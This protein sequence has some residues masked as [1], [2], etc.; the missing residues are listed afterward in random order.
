MKNHIP[1]IK[2]IRAIF[3]VLS[4]N[5]IYLQTAAANP[6]T[7]QFTKAWESSDI[8]IYGTAAVIDVTF[9]NFG[10]D[11]A[12]QTYYWQDITAVHFK[13][14][15]GSYDYT[16]SLTDNTLQKSIVQN[17]P[18]LTT[19]NSGNAGLFTFDAGRNNVVY[20]YTGEDDGIPEAEYGAQIGTGTY[21]NLYERVTYYGGGVYKGGSTWTVGAINVSAPSVP[22]NVVLLLHGMNSNPVTWNPVVQKYFPE[23]CSVITNGLIEADA[24]PNT[25]N[26]YCYSVKFGAFDADSP[27]SLENAWAY[28]ETNGYD[29]AGDYSTFD[30]LGIEVDKAI[31]G[32]RKE[33][34]NAKILLIGHSRGGLAARAFLQNPF[35]N[36]TSI[37]GLL[38]TGTPHNGTRLGRVHQYIKTRLLKKGG[39]RKTSSILNPDD[40]WIDDDWDAIDFLS[41]KTGFLGYKIDV[42]R[43]VVGYLADNSLMIKNLND[44]KANLPTIKY[45]QLFYAKMP[46]GDLDAHYAI[47]DDIGDL[48]DQVSTNAEVYIKG[49]LADGTPKPSDHL[50]L[51][52]DGIVP[53]A[54]QSG[55]ENATITATTKLAEVRHVDEP[56]RFADISAMTCKLSFSWLKSCPATTQVAT[57]KQAQAPFKPVKIV[58]HDYDA[59]VALKTEQLWQDW[60]AVITDDAKANQREQFAV[61]LGIKLRD[62]DNTGLYA[63]IEQ[64]VLN[65]NS[66]KLERARLAKLLAEVATPAALEILTNA[67]LNPDCSAIQT[68]LSNAILTVADS[69]PE[70]PRRADLSTVLET[71][72]TIPKQNQH[73]LN[74][75]ALALAKLGTPRGVELLLMAVDKTGTFMPSTKK[76]SLSYTEQQAKAAFMAMDEIINPDSEKMLSSAFMNHR[77][78]E[79]VFIAAGN[80]LV[81]LGSED[82]AQRVLQRLNELPDNTLSVGQH[83]LSSLSGKIDKT[84]L[85][86]M[87]KAVG[88]PRQGI[89]RQQMEEMVK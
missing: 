19:D 75:L 77:A 7:Y 71:A 46:L 68:A 21:T 50:S 35:D 39:T 88:M 44:G 40:D 47:F 29:S 86:R 27:D 33:L 18:F 53:K 83:W 22:Q 13:T 26:T 89:L 61:A 59:L 62:S 67:L 63:D 64:R 76:K 30:Q 43:P 20:G 5:I 56:G 2:I 45:G 85:R 1:N 58:S 15:S 55:L 41:G 48:L 23:G 6:Y 17:S 8:N 16:I 10:N 70:Q 9:D 57:A 36:K 73:Q 65:I 12:N 49:K 32:I 24:T 81:N 80:G 74:T 66:S 25:Q 3:L 79:A 87:N 69:L 42:R 51:K 11:N 31:T 82:A 14:N 52:G 78:T 60:L 37:V 38:T 28:G 72:W 4:A 34:P 84:A 54:S